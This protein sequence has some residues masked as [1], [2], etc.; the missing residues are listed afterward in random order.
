MKRALKIAMVI[1]DSL[2]RCN[3]K[4]HCFWPPVLHHSFILSLQWIAQVLLYAVYKSF[5]K[6]IFQFE[7]IGDSNENIRYYLSHNLLNTKGTQ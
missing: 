1:M 2:N 6:C 3:V 7:Y 5:S 4:V